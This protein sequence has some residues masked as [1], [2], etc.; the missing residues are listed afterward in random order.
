MEFVL[1]MLLFLT[2]E[3]LERHGCMLSTVGTDALVPKHQVISA[4]SAEQI[5]IA[6][7]QFHKGLLHS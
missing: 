2:H 7:E 4:H 1:K 5:C 3:Q 6:F